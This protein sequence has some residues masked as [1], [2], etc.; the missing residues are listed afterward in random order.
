MESDFSHPP[1]R[2]IAEE[3][4]DAEISRF[5][6][7]LVETRR[8]IKAIQCDLTSRTQV[9]DG[10]IL[11]AHLMVLDDHA[12]IEEVILGVRKRRVNVEPVVKDV[13]D[14][15]AAILASVRLRCRRNCRSD[16]SLWRRISLRRRLRLFGGIRLAESRLTWEARPPIRP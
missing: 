13:A 14:R 16:R 9:T 12:F 11:D 10:G 1:S 3:D 15:Y 4:V 2:D 8:Q 7:A 5:E 6:D